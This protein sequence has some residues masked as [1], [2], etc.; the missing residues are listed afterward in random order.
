MSVSQCLLG[1]SGRE[2]EGEGETEEEPCCHFD[3]DTDA[4]LP[5]PNPP[6]HRHSFL[7]SNPLFL[8]SGHSSH[9]EPQRRRE[10]QLW[11]MISLFLPPPLVAWRPIT[12]FLSSLSLFSSCSWEGLER[13]SSYF[14]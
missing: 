12:N 11:W 5:L 4:R 8:V 14:P 9:D 7:L 10:K 3:D 13:W 6:E 1:G 2:E